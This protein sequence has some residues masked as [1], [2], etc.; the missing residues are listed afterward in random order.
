MTS[1]EWAAFGVVF[2]KADVAGTVA[3]WAKGSAFATGAR[4]V[5]FLRQF[6]V[7]FGG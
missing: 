3:R 4:R 6:S 7:F 2:V 5:N 1:A